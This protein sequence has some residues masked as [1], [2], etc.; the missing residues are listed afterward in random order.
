MVVP[1]T[2]EMRN[3]PTEIRGHVPIRFRHGYSMGGRPNSSQTARMRPRR[4]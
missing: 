4:S 3:F 1:Q 2:G